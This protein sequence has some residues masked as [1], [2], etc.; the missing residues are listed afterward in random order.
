MVASRFLI[1]QPIACGARRDFDVVWIR[2]HARR[3]ITFADGNPRLSPRED[4]A[5]RIVWRS[6]T[7]EPGSEQWPTKIRPATAMCTTP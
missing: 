7:S 3:R 2:V 6:T 5:R 4:R 1:D